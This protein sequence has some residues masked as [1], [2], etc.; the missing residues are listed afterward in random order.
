MIDL[1]LLRENPEFVIK[2]IKKKDP[3]FNIEKLIELDKE[4]RKVKTELEDLQFKKNI[5]AKQGKKE[6]TKELIEASRELSSEIKAKDAEYISTL[7]Q[8]E[9]LYLYCPNILYNDV[10]EGG[11]EN[12]QVVKVF[13]EKPEFNFKLKN[14][15]ELGQINNWFDFEAAAT[16]SG[17]NF[18]LYK[19]QGVKVLY[20]LMIYMLNNNIKHGYS[21]FL[22]P[23]L[24]KDLSL[25]G[26][27]N[28]P[29]FQEDVYKIKNEDLYLTPTAEVNLSNVYRDSIIESDN[30]PLK[31]T[32]W[33][34]CFRKEAGG[35]GAQERGL[36]RLH[37]F[38][39]AEIYTI[40]EP[41]NS[42]EELDKMVSCAEQILKDLGLHYRISLLAAQDTG[43]A[44]AKTY[45]IEV[46]MPGQNVYKEVASCSDC[47]NFQARRCHIRYRKDSN[48]KTRYVHTLNAS[49]LALPRLLVALMETYQQEDGSIKLPEVLKNVSI[50][51]N[52][53]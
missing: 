10:P 48:L 53:F 15:I 32:A 52:L 6:V 27:G 26:S 50:D 45:D 38:E 14:H 28:L 33:T 2:Q 30:L 4:V 19:N 5:F 41:K 46:W 35:Y 37:Q 11:P 20:A 25:I 7:D 29:R 31:M 9:T 21:P 42:L 40:T 16:M 34:S 23:Y 39:K 44:S 43:F 49:S 22:P 12:N 3:N 51:I 17:S 18:A 36:I 13:G 1:G 8:F 47:T 24:V